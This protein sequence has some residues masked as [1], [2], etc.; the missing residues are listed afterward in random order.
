MGKG[1]KLSEEEQLYYDDLMK[2]FNANK[3]K[4]G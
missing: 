1:E 3:N 2:S 4:G